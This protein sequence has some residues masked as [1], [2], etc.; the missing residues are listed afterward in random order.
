MNSPAFSNNEVA[1]FDGRF[2]NR[3]LKLSVINLVISFANFNEDKGVE[4]DK[5]IIFEHITLR[6]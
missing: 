4:T 6:N 3:M 5:Y 1:F 2:N